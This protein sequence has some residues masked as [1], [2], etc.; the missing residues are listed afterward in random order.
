MSELKYAHKPVP[1]VVNIWKICAKVLK[2]TTNVLQKAEQI[3][4]WWEFHYIYFV[5]WELVFM[6]LKCD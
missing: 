1:F 6:Y 5:L 3:Q 4:F 2:L